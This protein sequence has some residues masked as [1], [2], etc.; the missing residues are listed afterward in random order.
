MVDKV[1]FAFTEVNP[2]LGALSTLPYLPLILTYQNR[3]VSVSGLLDT[4]STVN[5]LSYEIGQGWEQFGNVK[6]S[7][8]HW[9]VI[10]LGLRRGHWC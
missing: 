5:V 4:G 3:S 10:W 1:R 7:P 6:D 2:E 8:F 9:V